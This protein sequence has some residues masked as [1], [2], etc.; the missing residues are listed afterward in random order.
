MRFGRFALAL[1]V[2]MT[3]ATACKDSNEVQKFVPERQ[4]SRGEACLITNDCKS[5]LLCIADTCISDDFAVEA[6]SKVCVA[7]QCIDASDCCRKTA[8]QIQNCTFLQDEC[9]QNPDSFA[10]QQYQEDCAAECTLDCVDH[11]CKSKTAPTPECTVDDDCFSSLD[12]CINGQCARCVADADCGGNGLIC[13]SGS[14]LLGCA[15]DEACGA[16]SKCNAGRCEDRS[17]QS[18]R[19]CVAFMDRPDAVCNMMSGQCSI[20]CDDNAGCASLG[21][22]YAC[23]NGACVYAGCESNAECAAG[24]NGNGSGFQLCLEKAEADKVTFGGGINF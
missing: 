11:S 21:G 14:C 5:G 12:K 15:R 4:G 17:C 10:C 22:L 3:L 13:Q 18:D 9:S 24:A 8:S 2:L 20:P 6:S 7:A 16:L 19:E 1:F 23:T